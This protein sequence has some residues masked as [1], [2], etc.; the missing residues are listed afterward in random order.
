[1]AAQAL[2]AAREVKIWY[3]SKCQNDSKIED[4]RTIRIAPWRKSGPEL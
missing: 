4:I 1:M 3:R 2:L